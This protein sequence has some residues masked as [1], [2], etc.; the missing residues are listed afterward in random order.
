LPGHEAFRERVNRAE[1]ARQQRQ[2]VAAFFSTP[3]TLEETL[4]A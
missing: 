2:L 3:T 1:T 4:V